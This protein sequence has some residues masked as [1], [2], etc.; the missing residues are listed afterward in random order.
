[1]VSRPHSHRSASFLQHRTTQIFVPIIGWRMM[2]PPVV[3]VRRI[4][5]RPRLSQRLPTQRAAS[6]VD[7][8]GRPID[9]GQPHASGRSAAPHI[10]VSGH[11]MTCPSYTANSL[12]MSA[13]SSCSRALYTALLLWLI[14]ETGVVSGSKE[15]A[16]RTP[17][18][19]PTHALCGTGNNVRRRR[20]TSKRILQKND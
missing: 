7:T 6:R 15:Q 2:V 3:V 1:M 5:T 9:C 10:R 12:K 11:L 18:A 19:T 13:L 8:T 16:H 20:D 14:N 17:H 4:V